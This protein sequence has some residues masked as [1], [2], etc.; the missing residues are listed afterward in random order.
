MDYPETESY[1]TRP[2]TWPAAVALL[3]GGRVTCRDP[4]FTLLTAVA[5][6]VLPREGFS[7]IQVSAL[8]YV[9]FVLLIL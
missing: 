8:F 6:Y 2:P 7:F 1:I 4:V 5:L 3:P 9:Y